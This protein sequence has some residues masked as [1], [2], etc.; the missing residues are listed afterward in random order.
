MPTKKTVQK[1]IE[2]RGLN[3]TKCQKV[4]GSL[5]SLYAIADFWEHQAGAMQLISANEMIEYIQTQKF[6]SEESAA[7]LLGLEKFPIFFK[8]CK[9]ERDRIERKRITPSSQNVE[10]GE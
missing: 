8:A 6:S 5:E 1:L 3:S 2:N 10:K 9:D 7:F 4:L